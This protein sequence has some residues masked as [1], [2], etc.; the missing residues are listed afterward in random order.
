MPLLGTHAGTATMTQ[1]DL[2]KEQARQA[3]I[4][5]GDYSFIEI[6]L[7]NPKR[8]RMG[9]VETV[10]ASEGLDPNTNESLYVP[11]VVPGDEVFRAVGGV[12]K[13][14][15]VDTPHNRSYLASHYALGY[16]QIVDSEI[17]E[18]IR[19]L[20]QEMAAEATEDTPVFSGA[21][22]E[23]GALNPDVVPEDQLADEDL[24]A[25]IQRLTDEKRRRTKA[26]GGDSKPRPKKK[27]GARPRRSRTVKK[28]A[29]KKKAAAKTS[30][31][32]GVS[33]ATENKSTG[34]E[35]DNLV[36]AE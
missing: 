6:R 5:N 36:T 7:R 23:P 30:A 3:A 33:E 2:A 1:E 8:R 21:P 28:K 35:T 34:L 20:S 22:V 19:E 18:Q 31:N 29:A 13:V 27:V 25:Q 17:D 26:D 12:S 10:V 24:D 11:K 16:W 32:K 14:Y 15:L 4:E 9:S